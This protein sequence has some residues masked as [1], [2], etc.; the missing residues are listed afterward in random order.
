MLYRVIRFIFIS[1][2]RVVRKTLI[3]ASV[4]Q[5]KTSQPTPY[6][7]YCAREIEND[8]GYEACHARS[9]SIAL[10]MAKSYV[11]NALSG[12]RRVRRVHADQV[13]LQKTTA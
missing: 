4:V 7:A 3:S 6:D 9:Y 1:H 12:I 8:A 10:L 5:T 11:S 13:Q 2:L